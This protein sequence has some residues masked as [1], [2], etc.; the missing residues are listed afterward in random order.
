M[1]GNVLVGTLVAANVN[2]CTLFL[3]LNSSFPLSHQQDQ[4]DANRDWEYHIKTQRARERCN[5]RFVECLADL[6]RLIRHQTAV[7]LADA[8]G[9]AGLFQKLLLRE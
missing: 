5:K 6:F 8:F 3:I 4:K 9:C 7:N 2:A 1:S